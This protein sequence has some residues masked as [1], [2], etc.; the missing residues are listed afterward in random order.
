MS[1]SKR[2]IERTVETRGYEMDAS[3][4]VP[5]SVL[6]SYMEHVRW[7]S[8]GESGYPL[9]DYWQ[10]GMLR[11][12]RIEQF[13]TVG[14]HEKLVIECSLGRVG[15][16]SLD[17]CHRM[18]RERDGAL[19]AHAAATAVNIGADG[20]P[21]PLADAIRSLLA[22]PVEPD[23]PPLE[24]PPPETA[25]QREIVVVPSDQD[26]LQHV[27]HARYID[28]VE[29]TRALAARAGAFDT[30]QAARVSPARRLWIAYE[31]QAHVGMTLQARV[32]AIPGERPSF[33]CE[34]RHGSGIVARARV[35]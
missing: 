30:E 31:S 4:F 10:R 35:A 17:L 23:A 34:L 15:R 18:I 29:D 14:H 2:R 24:E 19:V 20:R 8:M 22:E 12:Q 9:R 1:S 33:G 6:A 32:W 26:L 11:A 25:W 5:L 13:A 21:A 28:F 3:G 16:T 7:Q 27:N